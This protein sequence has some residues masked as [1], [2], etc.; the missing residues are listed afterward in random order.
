MPGGHPKPGRPASSSVRSTALFTRCETLRVARFE[1][2]RSDDAPLGES[3]G[4]A[5]RTGLGTINALGSSNGCSERVVGKLDR[6]EAL[7]G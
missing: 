2:L 1:L 5:I 7:E 6:G 3:R 4:G